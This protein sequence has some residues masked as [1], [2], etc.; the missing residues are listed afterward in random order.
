MR[1]LYKSA[2]FPESMTSSALAPS[3]YSFGALIHSSPRSS[4]VNRMRS[5]FQI[6]RR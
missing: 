2:N 4:T 3:K 1:T 6:E 5:A